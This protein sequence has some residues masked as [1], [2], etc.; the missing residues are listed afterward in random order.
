M[1]AGGSRAH[2]TQAAPGI[3]TS[4]ISSP[5]PVQGFTRFLSELLSGLCPPRGWMV[6]SFPQGSFTA[7]TGPCLYGSAMFA[8]SLSPGVCGIP[9]FM[10][11]SLAYKSHHP[12]VCKA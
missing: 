5:H 8:E 6:L 3:Q 4:C 1:L 7:L 9:R 12:T 2:V 10:P 11:V